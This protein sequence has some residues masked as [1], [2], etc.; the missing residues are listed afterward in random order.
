MGRTDR[1]HQRRGQKRGPRR[2]IRYAARALIKSPAFAL[3]GIISM[4][5]GIGLTTNVYSS[6]WSMLTRE[7][8]VANAKR[9]A[10]AEKPVSYYYIER[11]RDEKKL[12]F[13]VAAVQNGAT[14]RRSLA[15]SSSRRGWRG[16]T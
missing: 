12:F 9:L 16:L 8:P 2:D 13:G 3:V 1:G 7:L 10:M 6:K 14:S 11:Y 15:A 5:L 4:S